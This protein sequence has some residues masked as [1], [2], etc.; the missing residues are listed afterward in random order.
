[1]YVSQNSPIVRDANW[2]KLAQLSA[3][4]TTILIKWAYQQQLEP[5]YFGDIPTK[6][7]ARWWGKGVNL[8]SYGKSWQTFNAPAISDEPIL[9]DLCDRFYKGANS[10]LLYR[11]DQGVGISEHTDKPVFA[12]EVVI[13]NL[14]DAQSNLFG[15]KPPIRFC[16]NKEK[17]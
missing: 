3:T 5:E 16:Y 6:R 11:Y 9:V 10:V 12:P 13:I 8:L 7:L 4:E 17:K 15:D 1:M 2:D 14:I